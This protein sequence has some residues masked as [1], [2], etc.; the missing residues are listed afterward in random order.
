MVQSTS[1]ANGDLRENYREWYQGLCGEKDANGNWI[2]EPHEQNERIL[3]AKSK[4]LVGTS[5]PTNVDKWEKIVKK[6]LRFEDERK[7]SE[8]GSA[9]AVGDIRVEIT[10]VKITK[11]GFMRLG[12]L[13]PAAAGGDGLIVIKVDVP[14][15]PQEITET[16]KMSRGNV[17]CNPNLFSK[18]SA[19]EGDRSDLLWDILHDPDPE[20]SDLTIG[21]YLCNKNGAELMG[22]DKNGNPVSKGHI[23]SAK[24][25]LKDMVRGHA[26]ATAV[27]DR[28]FVG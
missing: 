6:I 15:D 27:L 12:V 4:F 19:H 3:R 16:Y 2:R 18:T 21:V 22:T 24:L 25:C 9:L 5:K 13:N 11:N 26:Q 8:Q 17:K 20:R 14:G 23:G 1:V 28:A 10:Q 7:A